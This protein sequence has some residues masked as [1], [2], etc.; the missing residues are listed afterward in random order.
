MKVASVCFWQL[1]GFDLSVCVKLNSRSAWAPRSFLIIQTSRVVLLP[2]KAAWEHVFA[3][4]PRGGECG[5]VDPSQDRRPAREEV[6]SRIPGA[7][8]TWMVLLTNR[9]C[10]KELEGDSDVG[11]SS[12]GSL[13]S[14]SQLLLLRS[15][16]VCESVAGS[17]MLGQA[18]PS[19]SRLSSAS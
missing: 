11:S 5:T 7:K 14:A 13:Y 6:S 8:V 19:A 12:E 18:L 3:G 15:W 1:A 2:K 9:L 4:A 10:D 17:E 16:G